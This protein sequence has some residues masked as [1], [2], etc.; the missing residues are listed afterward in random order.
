VASRTT[1]RHQTNI[2]NQSITCPK[3]SANLP[4]AKEC[5]NI[6]APVVVVKP[7]RPPIKGQ[8]LGVT[9]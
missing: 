1:S 6:T 5:M 4:A 3:K 9:K 7:A 8:G 2:T